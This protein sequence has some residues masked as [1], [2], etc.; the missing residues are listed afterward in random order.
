MG[1]DLVKFPPEE[2][3]IPTV[4]R[5]NFRDPSSFFSAQGFYVRHKDIIYVSNADSVEVIKFLDYLRVITSTV[6]GVASDVVITK[7]AIKGRHVLG[8]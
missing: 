5:T 7:D 6:S 2:K 8:Q 4:Y 3:L 1:V